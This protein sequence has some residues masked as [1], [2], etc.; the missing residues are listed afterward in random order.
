MKKIILMAICVVMV[1]MT[2][3]PVLA[4]NGDIVGKIYSTDIKACI[5]GIW[6]ES[7]NIG[8]KT[9]VIAEDI[10]T[11]FKYSDELRTLIIDD[12]N[13]DYLIGGENSGGQK[14]GKVI[15][16]IYE[17]DI[18]T[19]F[20]GKELTAYSLNGKM[21]IVVEELG[22]DNEFSKIGGKYIW[23][24]EKRTIEL[25]LIYRY[26]YSM[27][28]MMEG[29]HYN[30]VLTEG[31]GVLIAEPAKAP[32]DG[33]Y[34]LCEKETPDNSMIPVMNNDEIIGYRC[35]FPEMR[36]VNNEDGYSMEEFQTPVEYFYV[37]KVEEMIFKAGNVQ[38]TAQDWLNYYKNHTLMTVKDSFET[39]DYIFL[40]SFFSG[41]HEGTD[42]L[43]KLSK[44]DGTKVNYA[45]NFES[46]SRYGGKRFEDVTIDRENEKVYLHY[47]VDYVI[48]LKSDEIKEVIQ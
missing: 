31:N 28:R 30:I 6:V 32:L 33:G 3:M 13:P 45:D 19:Y 2:M 11:Q 21:A 23:N 17:T 14:T 41:I 36:F 16:N 37:D 46:V 9:V 42:G 1:L 48:D 25:E 8:G 39:E 20:R 29:L 38:I 12:F 22:A 44:K 35:K 24:A 26:P 4:A 47:D 43:I 27:R 7:Y 15:G 5:N 18:K 10:T 40:Y 34:I